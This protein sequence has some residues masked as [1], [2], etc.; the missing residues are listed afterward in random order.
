[1]STYTV[2][3]VDQKRLSSIIFYSLRVIYPTHV[4]REEQKAR[5]ASESFQCYHL[6]NQ[7]VSLYLR[8]KHI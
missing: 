2:N 7:P 4:N 1:V 3:K 5:I 6:A 8:Q